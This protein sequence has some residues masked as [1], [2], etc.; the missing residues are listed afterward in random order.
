MPPTETSLYHQYSLE[1]PVFIFHS[2]SYLYTGQ[3]LKLEF[4][5]EIPGLENFHPELRVPVSSYQNFQSLPEYFINN[6][7]FHIGMIELISYWKCCCSPKLIIHPHKLNENQIAFWKNLYFEGLG[8]FFYLNGIEADADSFIEI[9]SSETSV[10]VFQYDDFSDKILVPVGGGKDSVVSLELLKHNHTV[11]PFV[12]NPRGA[13]LECIDASGI[14]AENSLFAYRTIDPALIRLNAKGF[15]NGHTPFSA[16]L[17]FVTLLVAAVNGIQ[18]I[19]LSN[20]SSA[21]ESTTRTNHVNHQYSKSFKFESDF[22]DY[23]KSFICKELEYFSFLRPLSELQIAFLF[24]HYP[25]YFNVFKSCN[26]GSKQDIWCGH[27]P[28]CLFA[29]II[30][31]PFIS[32]ENMLRIFGSNLF[33]NEMMS[34][35]LLELTGLSPIKPF[36]CVGTVDEVNESLHRFIRKFPDNEDFLIRLY[37]ASEVYNHACIFTDLYKPVVDFGTHFLQNEF[38][39][40]IQSTLNE[41]STSSHK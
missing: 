31:S 3:E 22:R 15:L 8:E 33:D 28:K 23:Y 9:E 17:A 18:R 7:V 20:E 11:V 2:Y 40:L 1:F 14:G 34:S 21:N 29:Y 41:F 24:S 39:E 35:S 30:L 19:A 16:M 4:H 25:V 37:M 10:N 12:L 38:L 32:R 36:E 6:L 26:V 27:C 13:T 5:F